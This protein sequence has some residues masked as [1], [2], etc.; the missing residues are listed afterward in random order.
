MQVYNFLF[1]TNVLNRHE[2]YKTSVEGEKK[3]F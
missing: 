1:N 2:L 3:K